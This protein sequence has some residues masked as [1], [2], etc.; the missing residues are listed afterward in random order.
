VR[1]VRPH[2]IERGLVAIITS[3][4]DTVIKAVMQLVQIRRKVNHLLYRLVRPLHLVQWHQVIQVIRVLQVLLSLMMLVQLISLNLL[5]TTLARSHQV[6]VVVHRIHL[7]LQIL[8]M[9]VPHLA[10]IT[11]AAVA[12][13]QEQIILAM[14][15]LLRA[16][17]LIHMMTMD[18]EMMK[19]ILILLI[20][21]RALAIMEP[22][23]IQV[24]PVEMVTE[25][26][27][28]TAME[29]RKNENNS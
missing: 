24:T 3:L 5:R 26:P 4:A 27:V 1:R 29:E 25:I 28:E 6:V 17:N 8:V 22:A 2:H 16:I 12:R 15:V 21:D 13:L 11:Q 20:Q 23:I 14:A 19:V 10:P 18:T 7:D 9:S